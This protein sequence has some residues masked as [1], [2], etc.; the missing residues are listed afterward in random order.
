MSKVN[1]RTNILLKSILGKDLITDDNIAVIELV[2]NS[3]DAG[4]KEVTI[5]FERIS[6]NLSDNDF[7]KG[8]DSAILIRDTGCGMSEYDLINKWLNIAYSEKK[9]NNKVH[10]RYQ[11]GNKGVGRFSCDRLGKTLTIFTKK[12][13]HNL[14]KLVIDWKKFE[15]IDDID[16]N[17]QDVDFFVE[18]VSFD[19]YRDETGL[20]SFVSGTTLLISDLREKWDLDKLKSLKQ[21]LE[22]FINPNQTFESNPFEIRL[23]AEEYLDFDNNQPK[24]LKINGIIQNRIFNNLSFKTT[25][26]NAKIS[27]SG[28]I[29]TS[30]LH[31][32]GNLIFTLVEE[33]SFRLLKDIEITIYYLNPYSKAYFTKQTGVRPIDFGS[34]F[35]FINGFRIP[36]YG[37]QGN[38][39]LGM[40]IRKGQGYS[41]YLGTREVIGRIEINNVDFDE[42]KEN[43][44]IISNRSGVDNNKHFE[45]LTRS[46]SPY[47]F[48]YKIFR[49]LERFVVEGIK[50]DSSR[51]KETE[52][53]RKIL[54]DKN[55]NES[56]E[57]YVEESL[58]RNKRIIQN[59]EKIIDVKAQAVQSLSINKSF[60]NELAEEQ[61]KKAKTEISAIIEQIESKELST[62]QLSS[63]I[64]KLNVT[65]QQIQNFPDRDQQSISDVNN[66]IE[67][68]NSRLDHQLERSKLLEE[69]A[70]RLKLELELEQQ[71]NTYLRTS[72]RALSE[73]AKGL[74]HNIKI[75]SKRIST[76]IDNLYYKI[77]GDQYKKSD[78]LKSLGNIKFQSEKALKISK[79][80][81]R[82]NFKAD[83][84]EQIVDIAK[85]IEQ[86]IS[87]YSDLYERKE[88]SFEV[89]NNSASLTKKISILDISLILDDLISNSEKAG[90]K[91]IFVK[92]W[93]PDESMLKIIFSDSGKGVDLNVFANPDKI[94]ELGITT[95]DGSGIGLNSVRTALRSIKGEIIFV[96]NGV[97]LSGAS[98]ELTINKSS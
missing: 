63:L 51:M 67:D 74:V 24:H 60:V 84:N 10:N 20:S 32:R 22:R 14:L 4:S 43:F 61:A 2:K 70:R 65:R 17:I 57:Q 29:I 64:N 35:L 49:R 76:T 88:M 89:Y 31:D 9:V 95:T 37:D 91:N 54:N 28:D 18:E 56:K 23:K 75:T 78:L 83:K 5:I 82:S 19:V 25:V 8:N 21:Q 33:N 71:K 68:L 92:M 69:E 55:W 96:G 44:F 53:E 59:I 77:N 13:K 94:F 6:S 15:K 27:S 12:R 42:D 7:K 72:S 62:E 86:Y 58:E 1:F 93:N 98:F 16:K 41:R 80:I 97:H 79:L 73:D 39:W 38:D 66:S 34:I 52:I 36:P 40:E 3:F 47:G 45:E 26:I 48:Y 87:I 11:A 30:T 46:E 81:T 85:Y 90:A 50:W